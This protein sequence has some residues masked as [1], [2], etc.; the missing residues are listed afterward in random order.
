M[1]L[2]FYEGTNFWK[3]PTEYK[4][5]VQLSKDTLFEVERLLGVRLPASYLKLM[6]VQNG[7]ELR[8]RY[9]LFEDGDAAV[10]PYFYEIDI[11]HGIGLSSV[12]IEEC[13]LPEGVVLLTGDLHSWVALDYRK[14]KEP[15]VVYITESESGD[16][17]W[18]EYQLASTFDEFTT[19]LFKKDD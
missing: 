1:S 15:S 9:V 3:T 19:R 18:E 8:F 2:L 4:P 12:F 13:G 14:T 6:D 11:E 17:T 5:G 7:G 16:G 10:V